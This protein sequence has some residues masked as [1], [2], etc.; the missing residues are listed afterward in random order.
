M[1]RPLTQYDVQDIVGSPIGMSLY[2][3]PNILRTFLDG[4]CL[5]FQK[6]ED[7]VGHWCCMYLKGNT[8]TVFNPFGYKPTGIFYNILVH[9]KYKVRYMDFQLQSLEANTCGRWC[10]LFLRY[11][12]HEDYFI[13]MFKNYTD[14]D[15]ILFTD[16]L[17]KQ[18]GSINF[19]LSQTLA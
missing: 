2:D 17:I 18:N 14:E 3:D 10:G 19:R 6:G 15:I 5:I 16:Y 13:E 12:W 4:K 9:S 1:D 8:I 7:E 11:M